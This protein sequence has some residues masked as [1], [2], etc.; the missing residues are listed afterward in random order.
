M[1]DTQLGAQRYMGLMGHLPL[2]LSE[3]RSEA[4]LICYGVGNTA[5]SLLSHSSLDRLDVVDISPEVLSMSA[6]FSPVH[7]GDPLADPRV[8]VRVED[9]RQHL[10]ATSRRYD[11][12]TSEPP[13]PTDAGVV[14]LYTQ[15]FNAAARQALKPGG[16]LA[17]WLPL[18]QLPPLQKR[19]CQQGPCPK[20]LQMILFVNL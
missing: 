7:G 17:Q 4:L 6:R 14:N 1:S 2:L 10:L 19:H 5:R 13:P 3:E 16:V 20:D 11:V 12:I 8:E 15:E 9:G 18:F